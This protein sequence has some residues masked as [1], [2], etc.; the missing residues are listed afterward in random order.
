MVIVQKK[1]KPE[2]LKISC[3]QVAS[4]FLNHLL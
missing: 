2:R 1:E 3:W 4:L